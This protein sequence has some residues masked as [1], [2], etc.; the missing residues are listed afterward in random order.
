MP[1]LREQ[2]CQF[3]DLIDVVGDC[4]RDDVGLQAVDHGA[5]LLAGAAVR[6]L[7]RHRR[8]SLFLI[9]LR[10]VSVEFFIE[11]ARRIIR[12]VEQSHR[13]FRGRGS[14]GFVA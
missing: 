2:A 1:I 12:D 10:E 7:D 4:K 14:G 5:G 13:G 6:L 8:T 9:M 11:F 3:G